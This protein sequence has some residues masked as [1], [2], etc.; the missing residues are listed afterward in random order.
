MFHGFWQFQ[1]NEAT[2]ELNPVSVKKHSQNMPRSTKQWMN[3]HLLKLVPVPPSWK[4]L[5]T[6]QVAPQELE[7]LDY[8]LAEVTKR[9][10]DDNEL[11]SLKI[12]ESATYWTVFKRK[13][14]ISTAWASC[15]RGSFTT[16]KKTIAELHRMHLEIPCLKTMKSLSLNHRRKEGL[17][18]FIQATRIELLCMK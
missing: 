11:E 18:S 13:K 6:D 7:C 14:Y 4:Y 10:R 5:E 17:L 1:I 3:K 2:Q 9:N 16:Q 8:V 12:M 15:T